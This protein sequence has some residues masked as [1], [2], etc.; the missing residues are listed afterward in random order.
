[1][2]TRHFCT[3]FDHNYLPR[4]VVMLESLHEH[5]PHAHVHVLCL[6]EE[7]YAAMTILAYPYVSLIRLSELEAVDPDLFATRSTRSLVEYYFTIT[8]CLPWFLLNQKGIG[9]ITYLDADMMFFS[10]PEP[11]F[12]EAG[13]ASVIITPHRF[14]PLTKE[15]EELYGIYNVSWLSFRNTSDGLDCLKW[16]RD[17]CLEWCYDIVEENRF[18]DQKY[19]NEFPERFSG[20]H[21]MR[22]SGGGVAPWNIGD[23]IVK[24]HDDSIMINNEPLIFY[25]AQHFGHIAGPFYS[26]GL[27]WYQ[28]KHLSKIAKKHIFLEYAKLYKQAVKKVNK[29]CKNCKFVSIRSNNRYESIFYIIKA[30]R[31]E[32]RRGILLTV[33]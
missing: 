11:I 27:L 33:L 7:C 19:L 21:S 31:K 24:M 17:S 14:T 15:R 2:T 9:E 20:V 10:S 25:H 16:Y 18:A 22:H 13:K 30:I 29:L 4:G 5:C 28:V 1:M 26:S 3:Y 23:S 8:P 12:E 6:S 32:W